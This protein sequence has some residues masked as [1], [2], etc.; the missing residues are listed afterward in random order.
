MAV[1]THII[2]TDAIKTRRPVILH[3]A[4]DYPDCHKPINTLAV[5]NFI[6]R[7]DAFDNFIVVINRTALPWRCR[8][9]FGGGV[10]NP[11]LI[12]IRYW[13]LPLGVLMGLSLFLLAR[14]I[15]RLTF[16]RGRSFD[17]IHAHKFAIEGVIAFWLSRWTSTPMVCSMRGEVEQKILRAKPHYRPLYAAIARRSERIYFVSA[18]VR[19]FMRR[20]LRLDQAKER[21]LPNFV[22]LAEDGV[23]CQPVRNALVAVMVL[24]DKRKGLDNLLPAFKQA[25]RR[26]SGATL[27]LIGRAEPETLARIARI[28]QR[29]RLVDRVRVIGPLPHA[30]LLRRLPRYAGM[31]LPSRDETFGMAYVEALFSG[32]PILYSKNTGIDGYVDG[33]EAA[34]GVDPGSVS[35]IRDGILALLENQDRFTNWLRHHRHDLSIRFSAEG[36]VEQYGKDLART[37]AGGS[38]QTN[39]ECSA[40]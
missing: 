36:Y 28:L 15:G 6:D 11:N 7:L 5:K 9:V 17:L 22:E 40:Y 12:S 21:L 27:D 13:G 16:R 25:L 24:D 38:T 14:H 35:A 3:I 32:V 8:T 37:F 30:E 31:L 4:A 19:P 34:V 1:A 23:F 18:W 10:R 20:T 2:P 39:N 26:H 29:H 33:V